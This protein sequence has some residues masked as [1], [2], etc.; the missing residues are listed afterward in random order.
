V[1]RLL[2]AV[3]LTLAAAQG[4]DCHEMSGRAAAEVREGRLT[5]A[6]ETLWA[7]VP[8]GKVSLGDA[9]AGIA[10]DAL[11]SI[12]ER[13]GRR[14][15]AVQLA[16]Q[17]ISIFERLYGR[18]NPALLPPLQILA[19]VSVEL[20]E[21]GRARQAFRRMQSISTEQP[22]DRMLVEGVAAALLHAEGNR[23]E[24]EAAYL[25][26]LAETREAGHAGTTDYASRLHALALLYYEE[27]RWGEAQQRARQALDIIDRARDATPV[28]R[29]KLLNTIAVLSWKQRELVEA[30]RTIREAIS[31]AEQDATLDRRILDALMTN[32]APILREMHRKKE[33]RQVEARLAA[34]RPRKASGVVD[35]SELRGAGGG[36]R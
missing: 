9:C 22:G 33:A 27:G 1:E 12:A 28:D 10:L 20:G 19:T 17:S 6:E 15:D 32:Y 13:K 35:V 14:E 24:A 11:A 36:N 2:I 18:A 21:L 7:Y 16:E 25:A 23:R 26:L 34:A 5:E 4:Q 31:I 29:L 30:E 8:K 3:L